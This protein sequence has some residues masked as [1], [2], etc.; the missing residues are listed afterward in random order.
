MLNYYSNL[1]YQFYVSKNTGHFTN[2]INAQVAQAS[3]FVMQYTQF[4]SRT[5]TA[6]VYLILAFFLN[7]QFSFMA[8]VAGLLIV[9]V[10]KGIATETKKISVL[11]SREAGSLNKFLIQLLQSFKYLR[12]T[13]RFGYLEK[14]AYGSIDKLAAYQLKVGKLTALLTAI[15]EPLA[16]AFMIGIMLYQVS[17]LGEPLAPLLIILVLFY[18]TMNTLMLA[19]AQWQQGYACLLVVYIL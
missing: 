8:M 6:I 19:Q 13:A 15:Q 12:S 9:F 18:R 11:N 2:V 10:L 7:W 1:D 17:V 16:I 3:N 4:S 5:L 14:S